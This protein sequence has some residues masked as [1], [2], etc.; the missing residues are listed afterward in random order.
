VVTGAAPG[1][2]G[3]ATPNRTINHRSDPPAKSWRTVWR[4]SVKETESRSQERS[5]RVPL[6]QAEDF[7]GQSPHGREQRRRSVAS[8]SMISGIRDLRHQAIT[9][10][11]E[12]GA[13]EPR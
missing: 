12:A 4:K 11:A 7:A 5:A 6:T 3:V 9:V 10:M 2:L 1:R 13:S 8:A